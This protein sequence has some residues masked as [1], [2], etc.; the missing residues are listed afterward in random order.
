MTF[1]LDRDLPESL[2]LS[3]LMKTNVSIDLFD[4]EQLES[5][6]LDLERLGVVIVSAVSVDFGFDPVTCWEEPAAEW[7]AAV[8]TSDNFESVAG[9]SSKWPFDLTA[10]RVPSHEPL[11]VNNSP[12]GKFSRIGF[13]F[14]ARASFRQVVDAMPESFEYTTGHVIRKGKVLDSWARVEPVREV[15]LL[16]PDSVGCLLTHPRPY[17]SHLLWMGSRIDDDFG[18]VWDSLT[19]GKFEQERCALVPVSTARRLAQKFP[20]DFLG[21]PV[22]DRR[23]ATAERA[24]EVFR[25]IRARL[26]MQDWC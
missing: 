23:S 4:S 24:V 11:R 1:R 3:S 19:H 7:V 17:R 12:R 26:P 6:L 2:A 18:F 25:T 21:K 14:A 5:V 13:H 20:G 22:F 9:E 15:S 16:S 10:Q 8:V